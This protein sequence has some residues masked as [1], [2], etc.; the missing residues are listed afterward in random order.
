M[1]KIGIVIACVLLLCL[2]LMLFSA[3]TTK[4]DFYGEWENVETFTVTK[5]TINKDKTAV[6]EYKIG[7]PAQATWTYTAKTKS[8][9]LKVESCNEFIRLDLSED[10]TTMYYAYKTATTI[11]KKK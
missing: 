11:F 1:K 2:S 6:I 3:C 10:N 9:Y 4:N 7:N 5:I 8:L